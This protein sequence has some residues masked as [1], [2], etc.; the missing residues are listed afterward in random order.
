MNA[1][2]LMFCLLLLVTPGAEAAPPFSGTIFLDPDIITATDPTTFTNLTST[3][4]GMRT[5]FD[6]RVNAFIT[7]NAFLFTARFNDGL[8]T[9]VQVNPEF[10]NSTL[11]GIDANKYAIA[12][13]R[14]PTVLRSQVQTVWI[15]KGVQPFGGG[16]NN[17]LIHTGQSAQYEADGI[18][19]ETFVHEAAHTSLDA[20]HSA[21]AGWL[22]A[23]AADP[24]FISTYARDNPT[25]EDIAE[26]FLPWLA[27]RHRPHRISTT[28]SNTIVAS[29]PNRLAYFNNQNFSLYPVVQEIAVFTGANTNAASERTDNIGTNV[30]SVTPVGSTSALQ[31][32]TIKN[33]GG[34]NLGPLAL[35][36]AGANPGDFQV[37]G[38]TGTLAPNAT[39]AF[40]VAFAPTAT[41]IRRAVVRIASNDGNENP[42]RI[43]VRGLAQAAAAIGPLQLQRISSRS[44]GS[45]SLDFTNS[46]AASFM[47]L[48]STNVAL[49]ITNWTALGIPIEGPSGRYQFVDSQATNILRR[50]YLIR[51]P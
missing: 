1:R 43:E 5:M 13:G 42:F 44:D 22:A 37:S 11:A 27:V 6:R 9:E 8:T 30:F 3:G 31:T 16:N 19:E 38:L 15:H 4:Q 7:V 47:V 46:P 48:A 20:A 40:T 39:T 29:I 41:G 14:L 36:S 23:Q 18:L 24:E 12:I 33:R 28:L 21:A 51:S 2:L 34:N 35:T 50:F 26:S 49:S 45:V 32:F 25:R 10:T 17:L